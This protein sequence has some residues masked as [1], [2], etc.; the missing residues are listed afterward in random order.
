MLFMQASGMNLAPENQPKSLMSEQSRPRETAER[1]P[2]IRTASPPSRIKRPWPAELYA[3][4]RNLALVIYHQLILGRRRW[5]QVKRNGVCYRL[6]CEHVGKRIILHGA[7]HPEKLN[8]FIELA[9]QH[10]PEIHIDCGAHVGAHLLPV[11]AAGL[12]REYYAIEGSALA[13][14]ALQ[15]NVEINGFAAKVRMFDR[16]LSDSEK[17]L[18]FRCHAT[19]THV[20]NAIEGEKPDDGL[21]PAPGREILKAVPLDSL[22][23]FQNRRISLKIDVE[24]HELAVLKGAR[25]LLANN[26]VLLQIEFW[27][28]NIAHLNWLFANGFYL[29]ATIGD[30]Y[31]LRNYGEVA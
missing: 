31:Y 7:F 19:M 13:F 14:A 12:A 18:V 27:D 21:P 24:G 6:Q 15:K 20:W 16:L 17:E 28:H 29:I 3:K 2:A 11:V 23:S 10:S 9:R 26:Q 22:V 25:Q 1:I 30:D 4:L 8:F 5:R